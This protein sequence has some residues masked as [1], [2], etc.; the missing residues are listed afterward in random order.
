MAEGLKKLIKEFGGQAKQTCCF[1]HIINL[2]V[3]SI[4]QQFDVQK[5][6]NNNVLNEALNNLVAL[7]ENLKEE[8]EALKAN[9]GNNP[10]DDDDDG[11]IDE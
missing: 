4:T 5:K 9:Y 10:D 7:A 6:G 11:W 8:E 2:V 3:K 1:N